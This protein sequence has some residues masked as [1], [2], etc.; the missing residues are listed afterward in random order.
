MRSDEELV[1][2]TLRGEL[3]AFEEIVKRHRATVFAVA[4]RIVRP[5]TPRT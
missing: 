5:T 2:Q 1:V 4:A 3:S